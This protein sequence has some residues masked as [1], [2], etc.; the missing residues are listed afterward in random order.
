MNW[1][2]QGR[3]DSRARPKWAESMNFSSVTRSARAQEIQSR[4]QAVHDS[5]IN[6]C[7]GVG[8][9][10]VRAAQANVSGSARFNRAGRTPLIAA[11]IVCSPRAARAPTT[12]RA[13]ISFSLTGVRRHRL[14][15]PLY[16]SAGVGLA[17]AALRTGH[18]VY[19]DDR[20][21]TALT[22]GVSWGLGLDLL[23]DRMII[24]FDLSGFLHGASHDLLYGFYIGAHF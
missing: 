19:E 23:T 11:L 5:I 22:L 18:H 9:R 12:L 17:A 2:L 24:R 1:T 21:A 10:V 15:A 6:W 16:A 7:G 4:G 20:S 13:R 3:I 14:R 8:T